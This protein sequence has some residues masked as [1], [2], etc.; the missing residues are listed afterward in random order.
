VIVILWFVPAPVEIFATQ[1]KYM[2]LHISTHLIHKQNG[3]HL[4]IQRSG[5]TYFPSYLSLVAG[6][7]EPGE[8][9]VQAL[10]REVTEEIGVTLPLSGIK[11]SKVLHRRLPDRVYA[12]YFFSVYRLPNAPKIMELN[13]ISEISYFDLESIKT[14]VVPYIFAALTHPG[15][16]MDFDETETAGRI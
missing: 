8:T 7:V 4:L 11:F 12:D 3:K 5:T 15:P 2:K 14:R 10:V 13:K 1:G 16:Y 6:H 9:P